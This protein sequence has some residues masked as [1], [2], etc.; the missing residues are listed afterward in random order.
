VLLESLKGMLRRCEKDGGVRRAWETTDVAVKT[1][2][3][4][5]RGIAP[6][7]KTWSIVQ[8]PV[9]RSRFTRQLLRCQDTH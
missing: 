6:Q 2:P 5:T 9:S 7:Q 4:A 3:E 8:I 1:W